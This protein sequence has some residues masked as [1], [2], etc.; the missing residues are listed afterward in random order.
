MMFT[1]DELDYLVDLAAHRVSVDAASHTTGPTVA[2]HVDE[3]RAGADAPPPPSP[4]L[5]RLL[6]GERIP[7]DE[8]S[9]GAARAVYVARRYLPAPHRSHL[10]DRYHARSRDA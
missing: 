8:L 9:P 10:L 1:D 4:E 6:A 5:A 7:D 2:R 3:P